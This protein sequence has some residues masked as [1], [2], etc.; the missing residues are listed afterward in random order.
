MNNKELT[1]LFTFIDDFFQAFFYASIGK[2]LKHLWD[3]KRGPKKK[4]ILAE[5]VTLNLMRSYMRVQDLK[6]FHKII[7]ENYKGYFPEVPNYENFFKSDE[8]V[9]DIHIHPGEISDVSE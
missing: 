7:M 3:N 6:P 1:I 4:L 8:S 5:V 9:G 2:K